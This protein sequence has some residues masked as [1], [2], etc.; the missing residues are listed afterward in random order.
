MK[1]GLGLLAGFIAL[2]VIGSLGNDEKDKTSSS[3]TTT[4][5]VG[6]TEV[7]APTPG[8]AVPSAPTASEPATPNFTPGQRNAIDKAEGLLDYTA[9]SKQG[10]IEQLEYSKFSTADATF[11]VENI[12]GN[13][14]VDWNEQAV[15]KAQSLLDYTSF[16]LD[17]LVGQLEYS[18]FTPSQ[19]QHGASTAYG[20]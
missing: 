16:S 7:T 6:S 10:L 3:S 9:F 13:G 5:R 4:A 17:G 12:E 19:A 1:I 18:G 2:V 20:G 8:A 14:G 15:R 11:A